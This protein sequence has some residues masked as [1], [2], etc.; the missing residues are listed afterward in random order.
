[1]IKNFMP[2]MDFKSLKD[3]IY[4]QPQLNQ[5]GV[6]EKNRN[7]YILEGET[8]VSFYFKPLLYIIT[9]MKYVSN[10]KHYNLNDA[11]TICT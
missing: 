1:M 2:Y 10:I 7:N 4:Q 3:I 8:I 11:S 9:I 6:L 5:P